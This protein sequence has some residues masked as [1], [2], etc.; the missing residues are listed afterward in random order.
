MDHKRYLRDVLVL[1]SSLPNFDRP[2]LA[3][4]R[5]HLEDRHR[6]PDCQQ[7]ADTKSIPAEEIALRDAE[8][9]YIR[10]MFPGQNVGSVK[11]RHAP[12]G[13]IS[14]MLE[15]KHLEAEHREAD[16]ADAWLFRHQM[17]EMDQEEAE[18]DDDTTN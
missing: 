17:A 9:D 15:G 16:R 8:N 12:L 5:R 11:L 18:A 1:A 6:C 10:K 3:R 2:T 13:D 7:E 14:L 4:V